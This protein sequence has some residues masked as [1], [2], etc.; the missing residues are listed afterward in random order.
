MR[1][2]LYITKSYK[3]VITMSK[4]KVH[5]QISMNIIMSLTSSSPSGDESGE[6]VSQEC[7]M[8][9]WGAKE[10]ECVTEGIRSERKVHSPK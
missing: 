2:R 5:N 8:H 3:R 9:S 10:A 4:P 6:N 7:R 1:F